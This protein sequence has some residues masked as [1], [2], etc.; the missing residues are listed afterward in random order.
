ME[1]QTSSHLR[2]N[3]EQSPSRSRESTIRW[4][5]IAALLSISYLSYWRDS[6]SFA[7]R[8]ETETKEFSWEELV[9]SETLKW[10]ACYEKFQCT[11]LS[12]P[13]D[14]A[15]PN[16]SK[17][18]VAVIRYPSRYPVGHEKWRGPILY[19][20]GGPGGSGVGFLTGKGIVEGFSQ[21]IGDDYDH[22]SFDP[23]GIAHTTP[24]ADIFSTPAERVTWSLREGPLVN[25]T[26]DALSVL[27]AQS[28]IIGKLGEER[29]QDVAQHVSTAVVAR[30][31]L[32]ITRAYTTVPA[33]GPRNIRAESSHDMESRI[34]AEIKI[35]PPGYRRP[36]YLSRCP[37]I[38]LDILCDMARSRPVHINS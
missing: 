7:S 15:K 3:N 28:V 10:V 35:I 27:Y 34:S 2:A 32:S 25:S 19:N 29:L 22:V 24:V 11:R 38:S 8:L 5:A 9:P 4:L 26:P 23:R 20:P 17:A 21:V 6:I 36:G 30:D 14:Y 18:A 1:K 13:L 12:V 31:M 37:L 16:G 33:R